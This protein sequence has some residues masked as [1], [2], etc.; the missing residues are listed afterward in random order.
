[1]N[2]PSETHAEEDTSQHEDIDD[3]EPEDIGSS[4]AAVVEA[5]PGADAPAGSVPSEELEV[6]GAGDD[7][8][9]DNAGYEENAER[10]EIIRERINRT[11]DQM[12]YQSTPSV[13]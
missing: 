6:D 10:E 5:K 8:D 3:L 2:K 7:D 1:M 11:Q 13:C 4:K 9:E 12:R